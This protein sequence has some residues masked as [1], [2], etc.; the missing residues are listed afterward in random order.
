MNYTNSIPTKDYIPSEFRREKYAFLSDARDHIFSDFPVYYQ[1]CAN[2]K[3]RKQIK[4]I[5]KTCEKHCLIQ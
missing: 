5:T 1:H 3:Y 2:K 4:H